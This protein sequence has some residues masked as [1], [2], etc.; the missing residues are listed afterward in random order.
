MRRP[1]AKKN[2]RKITPSLFLGLA[3]AAGLGTLTATVGGIQEGVLVFIV[4][5]RFLR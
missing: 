3:F 4:S 5:L 1:A 2:Y